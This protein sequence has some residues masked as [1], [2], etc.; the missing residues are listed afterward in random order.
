MLGDVTAETIKPTDKP[1]ADGSVTGLRLHP[2]KIK[3]HGTWKLRFISPTSRKRRDIGFGI[4]PEV[5]IIEARQLA[6]GARSQIALGT[7]PLDVRGVEKKQAKLQTQ[8]FTFEEAAIKV[9]SDVKAGWKNQ[10]HK[11]QWI[12]TLRTYVFP[13]IG[14]I[15]LIEVDM[16]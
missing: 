10:K 5:S 14:Q 4:Y 15:L 1:M 2:T 9:H 13:R 7:D 12:N 16:I 11:A 8:I 6:S 3:G